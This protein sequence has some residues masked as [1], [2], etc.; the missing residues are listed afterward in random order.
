MVQI[1]KFISNLT[2][3]TY[4]FNHSDMLKVVVVAYCKPEGNK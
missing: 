3:I 2:H 1:S 4:N